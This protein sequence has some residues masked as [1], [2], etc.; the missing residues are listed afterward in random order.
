[1]MAGDRVY[2]LNMPRWAYVA[3]VVA[4]VGFYEGIGACVY[5]CID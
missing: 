4:T 3:Y 2:W 5:S 1:M